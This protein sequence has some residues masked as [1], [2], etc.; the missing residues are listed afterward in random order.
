[1]THIPIANDRPDIDAVSLSRFLRM[2]MNQ[3]AHSIS[4]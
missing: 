3:P 1:V 2:A 4:K